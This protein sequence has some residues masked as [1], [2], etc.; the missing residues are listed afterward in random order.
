MH[1]NDEVIHPVFG[2]KVGADFIA[3]FL[4]TFDI[5]AAKLRKIENRL[6]AWDADGEPVESRLPDFS[7]GATSECLPLAPPFSKRSSRVNLFVR[8]HV[9]QKPY[10]GE[11]GWGH[12]PD[13]LCDLFGLK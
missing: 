7:R 9:A 12:R 13:H 11:D 1:R 6:L 3:P 10:H 2:H 5:R 4:S 8:L